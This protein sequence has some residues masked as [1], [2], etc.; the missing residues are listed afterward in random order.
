MSDTAAEFSRPKPTGL[1][2]RL[3]ALPRYAF[4]WHLGWM[5][6]HRFMLRAAAE[7]LPMV[8]FVPIEG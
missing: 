2:A 5:C 3:L 1:H 7:K 6:G 4:K 8:E